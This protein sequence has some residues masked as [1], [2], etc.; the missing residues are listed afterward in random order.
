MKFRL[1]FILFS[2]T[3]FMHSQKLIVEY[4]DLFIIKKEIEALKSKTVKEELYI[5]PFI[6]KSKNK[7][8]HLNILKKLNLKNKFVVEP[9]ISI[10]L[11][12][13]GFEMLDYPTNAFWMSP[14][15][16][17][18]STLPLMANFKSIWFYAWANFYKHSAIYDDS[19]DFT[20]NLFENSPDYSTSFFTQSIEPDNSLDFDQSNAGV[21]L[22][23]NNFELVFGKFKSNSWFW[24]YRCFCS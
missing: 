2:L 20:G 6:E 18:H 19:N 10:R 15:V 14:G 8:E 24:I 11:S 16:K 12:H 9:V 23:S 22:L 7:V 17:I 21:A 4:S 13:L 5:N 3:A 1:I